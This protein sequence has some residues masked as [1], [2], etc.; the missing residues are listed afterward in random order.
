MADSLG[1]ISR[2]SACQARHSPTVR[3]SC[4]PKAGPTGSPVW[5]SQTIAVP[6]WLVTA[7][8]STPPTSLMTSDAV[9][10]MTAVIFRAS[11]S[12]RPGS[13]MSGGVRCWRKQITRWPSVTAERMLLVPTSITQM[14]MEEIVAGWR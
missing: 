7:T 4:Q 13:G 2:P 10:K 9:S 14:F 1:T 3:R 6:R 12:T 5:R 8:A 11:N